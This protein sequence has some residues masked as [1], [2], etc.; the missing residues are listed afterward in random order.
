MNVIFYGLIAVFGLGA[1]IALADYGYN[2][3]CELSKKDDLG[4]TVIGTKQLRTGTTGWGSVNFKH[5][6]Y[7][8]SMT[9]NINRRYLIGVINEA[10]V[11]NDSSTAVD[12]DSY[13]PRSYRLTHF[14]V[15]KN[16]NRMR[17]KLFCSRM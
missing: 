8:A 3:N 7:Q 13:P 12:Y 4:T 6:A 11:S 16:N 1:N 9:L 15:D 10:G 14:T 5:G 17:Y 2:Y